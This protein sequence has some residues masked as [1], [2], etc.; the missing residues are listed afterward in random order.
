MASTTFPQRRGI[1]RG[2]WLAAGIGV[3][4]LAIIVAL[5]MG[6]A[7]SRA[8][9]STAATATVTR[10]PIV[11]TIAGSGTIA[12]AQSL[13]VPFQT[14][15]VVREVLVKEGDVVKA[16]QPLARLD[17]S[18]LELQ[19]ANAQAGVASAQAR[20]E[21]TRSGNAKPEDLAAARASVASAQAQLDKARSGNTTAADIA[22]TQA[23]LRSAQARLDALKNPSPDKLSSARLKV[24]Q[25]ETSL[26]STRDSNSATKTRAELD[27]QK[28]VETLTQA[29]SKYATALTNWQHVQDSG[30]DPLQPTKS[31]ANNSTVPNTLSDGQRQQYYDSYVQA[32]AQ[33]RSAEQSVRQAQI[34]Y[35]NARQSEV[36][37]VQQAEAQLADARQQLE[38]LL[39][40]SQSDIIQAQ[41]TVDQQ[42]A[43][44]QKLQQGGTKADIASARAQVDQAQANLDKLTAPGTETDL[45]IQEAAV[46]QAEQSLKQAQASLAKATLTAPFAGVISMVDM[47]PGSNVSS[48]TPV[49][50]L[51]NRN[52]LH[53]DLKV[54]ENDAAQVQV[55]QKVNLAITA[56]SDWRAE[57]TVSYVAPAAETVND[58]VTYKV[59]VSFPDTDQRVKVG[60]TA[61][62]DIITATKDSVLLVPNSALL[63]KGAGHVVQVPNTD[64]STREVEVQTGL[65]DG[66]Q[67]EI[68]D[69]LNEGDRV[70][71]VPGSGT[72]AR[73][74]G[75]FGG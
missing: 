1:S 40:P 7:G 55:G 62:L 70:V 50:T 28:A 31:G 72:P 29:Q 43:A 74:G 6:G 42:R 49:V 17:T 45:A 10:G 20:L 35:D 12:A 13:A 19:V 41:A 27:L 33:L 63:P 26:Q 53:I 37:N 75:P 56:L 3:I 54:S 51:I 4:V 66:S 48:A 32:E 46:S 5:V 58:V 22:S 15:G 73:Q 16:G 8:A 11:A 30:T 67:T 64:G 44:L 59:R 38:A 68:A 47:V 24:T 61:S 69:G 71:A 21:Q 36:T 52:P 57:G 60:M 14:N 18:D 34:T 39:N 65:S 2:G 9:T 23:Q 25:A